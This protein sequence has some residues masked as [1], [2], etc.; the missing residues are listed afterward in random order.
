MDL[1]DKLSSLSASPGKILKIVLGLAAVLL[2]MWVFTLSHIDYNERTG[3]DYINGSGIKDTVAISKNS[4]A[5][6]GIKKGSGRNSSGM[7]TNGLITFFVLLV[8][9]IMVWLWIDRKGP[10][11]T[12]GRGREIM[13]LSVGEGARLKIMRINNEVWVLGVSGS[14][15]NLLHRY[16]RE[17]WTEELETKEKEGGK[18]TFRKLFRDKL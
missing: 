18:G 8:I 7:F 9:L 14:S 6:E 1:R 17:E 4:P 16:S 11:T 15:V 13:S 3:K 2:L 12:A 5:T 10:N